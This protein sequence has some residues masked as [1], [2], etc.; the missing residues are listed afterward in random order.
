MKDKKFGKYNKLRQLLIAVIL[1]SLLTGCSFIDAMELVAGKIYHTFY[2]TT[3][4]DYEQSEDDSNPDYADS[5]TEN[6]SVPA[7]DYE[8][9]NAIDKSHSKEEQD[10]ISDNSSKEDVH[11][12]DDANLPESS[13]IRVYDADG[14]TIDQEGSRN[15]KKIK[16]YESG[17]LIKAS[18]L[19]SVKEGH[20]D[21]YYY[22]R[23]DSSEK[24]TYCEIYAILKEVREDVILTEKD[25]EKI[26]LAFQCVMND[27]PEIFYLS[28][29]SINKFIVNN[30]IERIALSGTY[31]MTKELVT[32]K[33]AEME[34][35]ITHVI[36]NAP[37]GDDYQKIKYVYEYL[38][39]NNSY[40]LN[41]VNNQNILSVIENGLT[42]CTGYAK[43]T[44]IL[45][46]RM[47][48]FCTLVDGRADSSGGMDEYGNGLQDGELH[49]WNIVR[50]NGK[51]YNVD[52]T[53]GDS[54]FLSFEEDFESYLAMEIGYDYFMVEDDDLSETHKAEPRVEM[55]KCN[56]MDDNYYV[57]EGYY[58]TSVDKQQLEKAF[59]K[60]YSDGLV[61]ITIK[62]NSPEVY[63]DM[64]KYLFDEQ[65]IF[66]YI[67]GNSVKYI[68]KATRNI[69]MVRL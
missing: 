33:S 24:N 49:V 8:E 69:I 17:E 40:D 54:S 47:G 56:S 38:I 43:S 66:D 68:T 4:Q 34:K 50:A 57:R 42:V 63:R 9:I 19:D 35:W 52:T 45:L 6:D 31:T 36:E 29:Y 25:P 1:C 62:L 51:Y 61:Y 26:D 59:D 48:I 20:S 11:N 12:S 28:G 2:G 3:A 55:P 30:Q 21:C 22:T 44:Q 13:S 23:L 39:R 14:N 67:A 7:N 16:A 65:K 18:E 64:N 46:N 32:E 15:N 60:A 58:F 5:E 41:A 37:E 53:W 10:G 27:H